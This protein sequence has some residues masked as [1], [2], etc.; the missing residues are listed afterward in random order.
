MAMSEAE[1]AMWN[2][3]TKALTLLL[4]RSTRGDDPAVLAA[5]GAMDAALSALQAE[6]EAV[7][8]EPACKCG[9]RIG[10]ACVQMGQGFTC[11]APWLLPMFRDAPA[12]RTDDA[13]LSSGSPGVGAGAWVRW[14]GG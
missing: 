10:Q 7:K 6:R 8:P 4:A 5:C 9:A 12:T 11:W 13:A 2:A 14:I 3:A 1:F